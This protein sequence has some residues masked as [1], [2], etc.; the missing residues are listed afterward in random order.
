MSLATFLRAA[1]HMQ[2]VLPRSFTSLVAFRNPPDRVKSRHFCTD[3]HSPAK[4]SSDSPTWSTAAGRRTGDEPAELRLRGD[5][6]VGVDSTLVDPTKAAVFPRIKA[7]SLSTK[8]IVIHDECTNASATLVLIAFRRCAD[9][10]LDSWRSP[11]VN[12]LADKGLANGCLQSAQI[13]DVTINETFTS[14]ALSGFVQHRQRS[15]V[16]VDLHDYYVAFNDRLRKPIEDL[17]PIQNRLYGFALLLDS[18]ARVRFRGAGIADERSLKIFLN[19][20]NKLVEE[21]SR[22]VGG[23]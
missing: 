1:R 20:A 15:W 7:T 10:Q 8:R 9:R 2:S 23:N 5:V 21:D 12:L 3:R 17:L 16:H 19:A 6:A 18:S 4:S 11:F 14:Q 13:F 22:L